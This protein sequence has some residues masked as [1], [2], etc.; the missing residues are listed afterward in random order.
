ML[1]LELFAFAVAWW[2]GLYLLARNP[3]RPILRR[4]AAGLLAYAVALALGALLPVAGRAGPTLTLWQQALGVV[5]ALAWAGALV[6][7]LPEHTSTRRLL[8]AAWGFGLLP[9]TLVTVLLSLLGALP[10]A[11]LG[12]VLGLAA[13]TLTVSLALVV[14]ALWAQRPPR[15]LPLIAVAVLFTA[16]STGLIGTLLGWLPWRWGLLAIGLDLAA[17]GLAVAWADAFDEGE[18]LRAHLAR[19]AVAAALAALLFAVPA[20]VAIVVEPEAAFTLKALLFVTVALAIAAQTL[21]DP[22]AALLD[23]V[24]FRGARRL[25][26]QRTVL[27]EV[28][29]ALPRVPD[30]LTPDL[31]DEGAFARL[32]RRALSHYG[33]LG[34]LAASPL[35]QL[36]VVSARLEARQAPASAIERADEL[37]ALLAEA[38]ARLK[39]RADGGFGTTD[40]WRFYNALYFPYV[41]GLKPYSRRGAPPADLASREA[42]AWFQAQVPERTLYNWQ[43]AAARLVADELR[44]LNERSHR[45]TGRTER[46]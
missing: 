10:A 18:A 46:T 44:R 45:P 8:D 40:E 3:R 13:I 22:L 28:A 31:L 5:P 2:L 30:A 21:A 36:E 29:D 12:V 26:A 25:R 41:V 38:I 33:D 7:L 23:R 17:L 27:R 37:K 9:L 4:A 24:T 15:G 20:G 35:T 14:S 43:N 19:S 42:L 11:P 32:V 34:R 39:P 16:L 1:A 6:L